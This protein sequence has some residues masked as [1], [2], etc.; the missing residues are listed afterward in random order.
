[1]TTYCPH[2]WAE[3]DATAQ[4][5]PVCQAPLADSGSYVTKLI[6]A[7]RHPEPLT[8]RRAAYV[9]GL[10]RD[11]SAVKALAAVLA[12]PADPYVKGEAAHALGAIGGGRAGEI[13]QQVAQDET[14][15]SMVRRVAADALRGP[16]PILGEKTAQCGA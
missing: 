5:C 10:L 1:M 13:L 3:V 14:Q 15:P 8:Q 7:L 2:C 16:D 9:L 6:A 12:G 4:V 11:P